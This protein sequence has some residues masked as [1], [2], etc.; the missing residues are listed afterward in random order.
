MDV[1][2][3]VAEEGVATPAAEEHDYVN[4]DALEVH[5]HRSATTEGV[6]A[7]VCGGEPEFAGTDEV[8][9]EAKALENVG[10]LDEL[11]SSGTGGGIGIDGRVIGGAGDGAKTTDEFHQ[12]NDGT[13]ERVM[14]AMSGDMLIAHVILLVLESEGDGSGQM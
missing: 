4:R 3:D 2:A 7:D 9:S 6:Q 12:L 14:S 1:A 10:G 13:H 11:E 5:R 8:D